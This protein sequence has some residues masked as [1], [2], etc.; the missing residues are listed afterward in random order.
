MKNKNIIKAASFFL[1]EFPDEWTGEQVIEGVRTAHSDVWVREPF[2]SEEPE[3]VA[4]WIQE[5]AYIFA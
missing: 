2:D 5:V 1:S 4:K 3:T